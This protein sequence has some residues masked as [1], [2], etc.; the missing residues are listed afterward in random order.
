MVVFT[1]FITSLRS[2]HLC[3]RF[4]ASDMTPIYVKASFETCANRDV[5]G[6]YAKAAKGGVKH[7]TGKDSSFEEPSEDD[8]DW[9]I[10]T[11]ESSEAESIDT[12]YQR[13]LPII[14]P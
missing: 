10:P 3:G 7:F 9:I 4:G 5:K 2:L 8:S 12:L 11:D 14:R 1:S 13:I 6:L